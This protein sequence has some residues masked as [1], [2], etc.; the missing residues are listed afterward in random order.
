MLRT[1]GRTIGSTQQRATSKPVRSIATLTRSRS[2]MDI[3]YIVFFL[4]SIGQV[5]IYIDCNKKGSRQRTVVQGGGNDRERSKILG[6]I[7]VGTWIM[8]I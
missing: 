8:Y 6:Y 7:V 4:I 1:C 3:S 5:G 2:G